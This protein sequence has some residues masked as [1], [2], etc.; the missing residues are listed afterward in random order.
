M[1]RPLRPPSP[2]CPV[3]VSRFSPDPASCFTRVA[4]PLPASPSPKP[5][6]QPLVLR[7]SPVSQP[8]RSGHPSPNEITRYYSTRPTHSIHPSILTAPLPPESST[9]RERVRIT[10]TEQPTQR[11]QPASD[12]YLACPAHHCIQPTSSCCQRRNKRT[13]TVI[14]PDIQSTSLLPPSLLPTTTYLLDHCYCC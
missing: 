2:V 4:Q 6:G 1:P 7:L 5:V 14:Q 12:P 13:S 9:R 3:Q 8:A 11:P 10:H